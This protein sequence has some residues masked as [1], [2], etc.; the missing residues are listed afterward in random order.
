MKKPS[1]FCSRDCRRDYT[2]VVCECE[3]CGKSITIYRNKY[4]KI[5]SGEQKTCILFK[6][7]C[8]RIQ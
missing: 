5:L 8:N 2:N 6:G 3:Y 7:M 1:K 4:Q